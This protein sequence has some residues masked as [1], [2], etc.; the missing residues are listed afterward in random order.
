MNEGP[1]NKFTLAK[2]TFG[3]MVADFA[4]F[5]KSDE[6]NK[7]LHYLKFTLFTFSSILL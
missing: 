3:I 7:Y 1:E 4:D 6:D 5:F 2:Y